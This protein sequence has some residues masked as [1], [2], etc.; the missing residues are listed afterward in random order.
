MYGKFYVYIYII[1]YVVDITRGIDKLRV[2]GFV[3][4]RLGP[5]EVEAQYMVFEFRL[6]RGLVWFRWDLLFTAK[7]SIASC[8]M[9]GKGHHPQQSQM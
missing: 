8:L 1:F 3:K 4:K 2:V 5:D 9:N 7:I 6:E